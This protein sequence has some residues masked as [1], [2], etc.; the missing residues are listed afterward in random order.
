[1]YPTG[2]IQYIL[3][4]PVLWMG[5]TCW[6]GGRS[7]LALGWYLRYTTIQWQ[8][9]I[10]S[11]DHASHSP[12]SAKFTIYRTFILWRHS[13]S[14]GNTQWIVHHCNR[15]QCLSLRLLRRSRGEIRRTSVQNL[16]S[17]RDLL[18]GCYL[19]VLLASICSMG[20][21]RSVFIPVHAISGSLSVMMVLEWVVLVLAGADILRR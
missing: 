11:L 4:F 19:D 3:L 2:F 5:S 12:Y 1:M 17:H 6:M 14:S 13:H 21:S 20:L 15:F 16:S 10:T 7:R 18:M 9:R 8:F